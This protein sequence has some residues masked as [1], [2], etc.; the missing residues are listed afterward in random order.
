M[1]KYLE[2]KEITPL[3][4]ESEFIRS[5]ITDMTDLEIEAV[6]V[7]MQDIMSDKTYV[8]QIHDCLHDSGGS[9]VMR[10]I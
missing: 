4:I 5:D 3:G 7:S 6:K 8:L 10:G 9:C 2:A 1:R